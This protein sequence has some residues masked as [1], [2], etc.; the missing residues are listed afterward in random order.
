MIAKIYTKIGT[1]FFKIQEIHEE[2]I[3]KIISEWKNADL[4]EIFEGDKLIFVY[5]N[6]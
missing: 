5:E 1:L 3:E 2:E 4:I 6:S